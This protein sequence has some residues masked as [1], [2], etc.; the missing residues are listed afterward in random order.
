MSAISQNLNLNIKSV[1]VIIS[2]FK[3]FGV[4]ELKRGHRPKKLE[5]HHVEKLEK[6]VEENCQ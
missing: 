2:K 4:L 5:D 3:K 6:L 1:S